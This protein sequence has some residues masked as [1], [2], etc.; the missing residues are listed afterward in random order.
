MAGQGG[1]RRRGSPFFSKVSN[2]Y[3]G[4]ISLGV[5]LFYQISSEEGI[6]SIKKVSINNRKPCASCVQTEK[7]L[8][9]PADPRMAAKP[10]KSWRNGDANLIDLLIV[11]P[12]AVKDA[13]GGTPQIEALDSKCG[14]RYKSCYRNSL[15]SLQASCSYG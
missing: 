1:W 11:Y 14:F 8:S 5:N 6:P 15:V 7:H 3:R 9:L 10:V 4:S 12:T 2:V 13:A